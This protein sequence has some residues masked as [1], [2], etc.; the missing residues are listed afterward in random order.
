MTI[1]EIQWKLTTCVL[2]VP[3]DERPRFHASNHLCS[4]GADELLL[5][6]SATD[7]CDMS[8]CH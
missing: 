1:P 3:S 2:S 7:N 8:F 6:F 5:L 4:Q